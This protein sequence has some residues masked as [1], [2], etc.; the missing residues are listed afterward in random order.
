[1]ALES[2]ALTE[3]LGMRGEATLKDGE[4]FKGAW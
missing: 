2:A 3:K 4:F 1:M